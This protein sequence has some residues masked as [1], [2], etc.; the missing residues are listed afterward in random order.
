MRWEYFWGLLRL[1][2]TL[3]SERISWGFF[4]GG[5]L[6]DFCLFCCFVCLLMCWLIIRQAIQLS[7]F[8]IVLF[9]YFWGDFLCDST[10]EPC[11]PAPRQTTGDWNKQTAALL[12]HSLHPPR[13]PV[14]RPPEQE[15]GLVVRTLRWTLDCSA[16][17]AP[18]W[19]GTHSACSRLVLKAKLQLQKGSKV[20]SELWKKRVR[21]QV[22]PVVS[23][24]LFCHRQF[25]SG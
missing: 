22:S 18:P 14:Q 20:D 12:P 25:L 1:Q 6:L 5:V 24:S 16:N 8:V 10:T 17:G 9:T 15:E 23:S 11:S 13:G 3:N 7:C 19:Q 21:F 2:M 4:L